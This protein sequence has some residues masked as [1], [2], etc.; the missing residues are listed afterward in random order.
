MTTMNLHSVETS[1]HLVSP[2]E[3]YEVDL[4]SPA[5]SVFTD[6]KSHEPVVIDGAMRAID[7]AVALRQSQPRLR[8]VVDRNG[9]FI[10]TITQEEL[11]QANLLRLVAAGSSRKD[12]LVTDVMKRRNDLRA[13]WYDD[14]CHAT[15]QDLMDTLC[16]NGESHCLVVEGDTHSIRGLVAASDVERRLHMNLQSGRAPTFAE[17]FNAVHG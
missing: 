6:F 9:E 4:H 8:L 11:S 12:I 5:L 1:D 3:Y 10:G 16:S 15:V 17:I 13:L 2:E 7:A 14:L